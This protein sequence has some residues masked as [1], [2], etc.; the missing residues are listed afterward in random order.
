MSLDN[1]TPVFLFQVL[2]ISED[3]PPW[4]T[5]HHGK[6]TLPLVSSSQSW[7][8]VFLG[9]SGHVCPV[10]SFVLAITTCYPTLVGSIQKGYS[11]SSNWNETSVSTVILN[12]VYLHQC[13][14]LV[15]NIKKF[16]TL[17]SWT[18]RTHCT[19]RVGRYVSSM[20][21]GICCENGDRKKRGK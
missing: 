16:R 15:Q 17:L 4:L 14:F 9:A 5:S 10:G 6:P 18:Q 19:W 2:Q 11:E 8:Q 20:N 3:R 7:T 21:Y 12:S 13:A 1:V